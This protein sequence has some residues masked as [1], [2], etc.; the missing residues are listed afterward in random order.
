MK[1]ITYESLLAIIRDFQEKKAEDGFT[2]RLDLSKLKLVTTDIEVLD[3]TGVDFSDVDLS[4]AEFYN[5]DFKNARF[6]RSILDNMKARNTSFEG[7][8]FVDASLKGG[9]F[10]TC[11]L[12][13]SDCDGTDFT[14]S[15]LLDAVLDGIKDSPKTKHFRIHCP[16]TGYFL[17][18]KKCFNDRLVTLLIG[19]D[20]KR[21]SS[22][23]NACRCD[24]A[25]VVAITNLDGTGAYNEAV[26]FVDGN[27][28]YRLGKEAV[29]D[30]YHE[31]RWLDSSHGIHFW[32]TKEEALGYM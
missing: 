12:S 10:R 5:I 32:M 6:D 14:G 17:G 22:T 13:N 21:C 26:S 31:D 15:I 11:N 20:S 4:W 29:A 27:F 8:S 23:T 16:E 25:K 24:R 28:I 7:A 3:L 30:S 2:E 1:E 18:Y 9:D 19:K